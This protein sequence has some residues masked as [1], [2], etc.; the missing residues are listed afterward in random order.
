MKVSRKVRSAKETGTV[1]TRRRATREAPVTVPAADPG[2]RLFTADE[3]RQLLTALTSLKQGDTRVGLPIEWTGVAGKL[4]ETF[5]G[6]VDL[7]DRI[8]GELARLREKVG[9][10]GKIKHRAE[11]SDARG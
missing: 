2:E 9:R 3:A 8:T 4:A 10:E 6:V 11:V 1:V 5:N 7:H